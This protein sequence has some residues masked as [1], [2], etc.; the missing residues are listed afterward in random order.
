VGVVTDLVEIH[1]LTE[2]HRAEN[3]AFQRHLNA[4]HVPDGPFRILSRTVAERID[5]T[6]CA[7]CCR[8][9]E[10]TLSDFDIAAIAE[11]LRLAPA[12]VIR[13]YTVSDPEDSAGRVLRHTKD[14]CIFLDGTLCMVYEA[15]PR[16]CRDFPHLGSGVRSL[17]SRLPSVF[18]RA[19][20]C[21]IV[22]NVL[23]SYKKL[24]GY[25]PH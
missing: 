3:L 20:I 17:G 7:N 21:P 12:D 5:C 15:R 11:H 24:I 19:S 2:I 23:E 4:H 1:R 10:V 9:T 16:A 6:A 14:G 18:K 25:H 8:H 22:Y 13:Q